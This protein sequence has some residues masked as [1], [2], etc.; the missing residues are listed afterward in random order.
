[1]SKRLF[2]LIK[3]N[4]NRTICSD[5]M[6]L[7]KNMVSDF[8]F[9]LSS[10]LTLT[11]CKPFLKKKVIDNVVSVY[12]NMFTYL[13][14]TFSFPFDSWHEFFL[15]ERAIY[16]V[17][18]CILFTSV[19][20]HWTFTKKSMHDRRWHGLLKIKNHLTKIFNVAENNLI[21]EF[22]KS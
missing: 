1:M 8:G 2:S 5:F 16:F 15:R 7:G 13:R 17:W 12:K 21:T 22:N 4:P 18:Y 19:I 20:H 3:L 11:R 14:H 10:K 6:T 9:R